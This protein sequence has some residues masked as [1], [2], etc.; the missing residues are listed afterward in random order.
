MSRIGKNPV[1]IPE[2]VDVQLQGQT[3]KVKGKLGELSLNVHDEIG[4]TIEDAENDDGKKSKVVRLTPKTENPV[5]REVWPTMRTLVNNMIIGVTEGYKKKL[6]I[7][8]VGLRANLQGKEIVMSLGFSHEVRYTV[9]AGIKVEI[10]KQTEL[11]V[12]GIDKQRVGQVS[13]EIREH[14]KPEPYKG[15]GIR[16]AGEYIAY[17]EGKKK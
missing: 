2:G 12:S 13:A 4:V 15:K 6:E 3:V 7:H 1:E 11:T 9:P 8:G 14:K 16:Y 5:A 17:K 10:E